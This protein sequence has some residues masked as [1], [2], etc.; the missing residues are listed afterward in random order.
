MSEAVRCVTCGAASSHAVYTK[1]GL[2]IVECPGCGLHYV[3]P[4]HP[5]EI[6]WA[7]Y[8]EAY[9]FDEYLPAQGELRGGRLDPEAAARK[10]GPALSRLE[11]TL[12]KPGRLL[13]VAAGAGLFVATAALRGWTASG[14]ELSPAAVGFGRRVLGVDLREGTAE[15]IV[16]IGEPFDAVT[17]FDAIEHFYDPVAVLRAAYA[18]LRP[19]GIIMITT[20]NY[21]A[22]SRMALGLD[23]AILSPLEH[24]YYFDARSMRAAL[25]AAGFAQVSIHRRY[26][27]WKLYETMNPHHTHAPRTLRARAYLAAVL[28]SWPV[29][30]VVQFAGRGDVLAV[31]AR[32]PEA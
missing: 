2:Q 29:F 14:V 6:V 23:W 13:D 27:G 25:A 9:F 8:S 32:K 10:F 20:P 12:G 4:R 19:G 1:F 7:R 18:V 5:K 3:N 11:S 22:L 28:A 15:S 30:R 21:Q 24:L 17:L 31:T 16:S 26:S